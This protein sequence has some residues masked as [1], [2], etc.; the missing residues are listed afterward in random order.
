MYF[1]MALRCIAVSAAIAFS[2]VCWRDC[3][4]A[5]RTAPKSPL[6]RAASIF[7]RISCCAFCAMAAIFAF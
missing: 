7:W 1:S 6:S 5:S 4:I 3:S 2:W